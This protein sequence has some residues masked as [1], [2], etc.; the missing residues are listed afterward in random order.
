MG[1]EEARTCS[2]DVDRTDCIPV[3]QAVGGGTGAGGVGPDAGRG[4]L[5]ET[6]DALAHPSALV[7]SL[8][9]FERPGYFPRR[10]GAGSSIGPVRRKKN[11]PSKRINANP[12]AMNAGSS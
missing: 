1:W 2:D 4:G 3:L 8:T 9:C 12:A 10:P 7:A 5:G 11:D 6:S